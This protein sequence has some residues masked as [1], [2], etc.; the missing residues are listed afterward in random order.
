[1]SGR[2]LVRGGTIVSMDRLGRILRGDVLVQDGRIVALGDLGPAATAD[3][4]VQA[5]GM[6]VLPGL[7]QTHVHLCQTLFRGVAD[8]LELLEWLE[9]RI[10]PLEAA[11]D[12]ESVAASARLGCAELI[13]GG[14]TT[15]VDMGTVHHTGATFE[16]LEESGLRA[17]AGKC[18]MDVG[19][20]VPA[21]LI[22]PTEQALRE[23]VE[24]LERWDGSAGGRLRYAFAPRFVLSCTEGLLR[25]VGRL[26][27]QRDVLVHTHA[28]ESAA[29]C[30]RVEAERGARNVEYF[31]RLRLTG[32]RLLLAHC[33]HLADSEK[34]ILAATRTAVAHCPSSNLKLGSGIA[35]IAELRG[36]GVPVGIGA[37]GAPCNNNL[38]AFREMRLA[39]LLQGVVAGPAALSAY[40]ALELATIG[41]ARAIGLD[42]EIGSLEPGKKADLI[43]VDL[44]G[45][46]TSPAGADPASAVSQLVFAASASDVRLTMVDGH[47]LMQDRVLQTLDLRAVQDQANRSVSALKRRA[48][49]D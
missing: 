48:G 29:E 44:S 2:V 11:H 19:A 32:P 6:A 21:G 5:G 49:L 46:H 18:L 40:E 9:R 35:R 12:R 38:D 15:L 31:D 14:T 23:S 1:M 47:I 43:L 30:A 42:A 34:R 25:E 45:P 41:G 7:I 37:D 17:F 28:A 24:L 27:E 3:R 10:W 36:L 22:E 39:S 33:I 13:L 20:S 26:A 4:V 16:V 8:G